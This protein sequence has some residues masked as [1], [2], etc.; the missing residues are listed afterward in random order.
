MYTNNCF[1]LPFVP[2]TAPFGKRRCVVV[3]INIV[4]TL[5][6]NF[7]FDKFMSPKNSWTSCSIFHYKPKSEITLLFFVT[8]CYKNALSVNASSP[9]L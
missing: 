4:N 5:A 3:P 7:I 9:T 1:L 6:N 2:Q 8:Y